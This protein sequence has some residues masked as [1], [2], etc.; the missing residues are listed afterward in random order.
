MTRNLLDFINDFDRAMG[1]TAKESNYPKYNIA[2]IEDG[3]LL[4]IAALG[5]TRDDLEVEFRPGIL[6]VRAQK[7]SE[8]KE[9]L[10]KSLSTKAFSKR[11]VTDPSLIVDKVSLDLGILSIKLKTEKQSKN[12]L[13]IE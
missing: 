7:T 2:K 11:F 10:E 3:Y 1:L 5:L 13:T 9:Y 6:E 4:E 8:S 12:L